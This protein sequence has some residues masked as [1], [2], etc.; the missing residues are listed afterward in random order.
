MKN[1]MLSIFLLAL[2]L[3]AVL[4]LP[5]LWVVIGVLSWVAAGLA[6]LTVALGVALLVRHPLRV[7]YV[8]RG[9]FVAVGVGL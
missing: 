3:G 2:V 4:P 9:G 8:R 5:V 6:V 1:I 7:G